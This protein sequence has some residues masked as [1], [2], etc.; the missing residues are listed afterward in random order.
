MTIN[1]IAETNQQQRKESEKYH[2]VFFDAILPFIL[3][4]L[5]IFYLFI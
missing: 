1:R 5:F 3:Y 2:F 4:I